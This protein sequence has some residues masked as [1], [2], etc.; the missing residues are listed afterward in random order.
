MIFVKSVPRGCE[1]AIAGYTTTEIKES[2][3]QFLKFELEDF[4]CKTSPEIAEEFMAFLIKR[5]ASS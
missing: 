2:L 1:S 5:Y 3:T 4:E